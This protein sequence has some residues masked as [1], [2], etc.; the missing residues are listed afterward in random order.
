MGCLAQ[1]EAHILFQMK[2]GEETLRSHPDIP[3]LA[4]IVAKACQGLP[5]ALIAIGRAMCTQKTREDW[6]RAIRALRSFPSEFSGMGNKV[7]PVLKFSYDSL[8]FERDRNCFLFC[9][10]FPEDYNIRKDELINLWIGEGLLDGYYRNMHDAFNLGEVIVGTLKQAC[11]LESDESE[12]FV[13]MHDMIR[14]M[15]LWVANTSGR[16]G[17]KI[18]VQHVGSNSQADSC[19]RWNEAERISV[20][21]HHNS[22]ESFTGEPLCPNLLTLLVKDTMLKTF[23]NEFFQSMHAL[24]VLDLSGNR[25]LTK[26]PKSI[27]KLLNLEYLN[28][29]ET[30]IKELPSELKELR[31]LKFLLLDYTKKLKKIS[32]EGVSSLSCLQV[33]SMV[34]HEFNFYG[35]KTALY[36]EQALLG[37]LE[38]LNLGDLRI[39]IRSASGAQKVM[40]HSPMLQKCLKMLSINNCNLMCLEL[41]SSS[42]ER[43]NRLVKLEITFCKCLNELK[44]IND[45]GL[46]RNHCFQSLHEVVIWKCELWS[47]ATWLIY[48]PCLQ[49]LTI[50]DCTNMETVATEIEDDEIFSSLQTLHLQNL[51]LLRNIYPRALRFPALIEIHVDRCW[52]LEKLPL[53]ASSASGLKQIKGQTFWWKYLKWE[54]N[55]IEEAFRTK[56]IEI[57]KL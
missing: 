28:L 34:M 32:A 37:E 16:G 47:H 53:N 14:D 29:S 51:R 8:P 24:K 39:T 22:I 43:M 18:L 45:T 23:S 7:F 13:R 41:S 3:E 50:A 55:A 19:E 31:K 17:N 27:G 40:M 30:A 48:A 11:L 26:L 6:A 38:R 33:F 56:F 46:T 42:L 4:K 2:V 5:L 9:S 35:S 12:E 15:A 20:W 10:L 21:G 36:N 52:S 54:D 1:E 25:G 57:P 44:I 49:K